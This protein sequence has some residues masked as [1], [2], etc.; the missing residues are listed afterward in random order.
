MKVHI[1]MPLMKKNSIRFNPAHGFQAPLTIDLGSH[2]NTPHIPDIRLWEHILIHNLE[3]K[4]IN[5]EKVKRSTPILNKPTPPTLILNKISA[6]ILLHKI[7]TKKSFSH[8][9]TKNRIDPTLPQS[10]PPKL[11]TIITSPKKQKTKKSIS[12]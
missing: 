3:E 10:T 1:R 9:K 5:Y 7:N 4:R 11:L 2:T 8:P 6:M 12:H